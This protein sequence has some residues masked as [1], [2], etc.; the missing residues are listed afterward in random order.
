[1]NLPVETAWAQQRRVQNI[2][3]VRRSDQD[4]TFAVAEAVHLYQQLVEGLL[5]LIVSTTGSGS[6]LATNRVDLVDEDDT[7]PIF[8]SLLNQVTHARC[9]NTDEHFYEVRAGDG[10]ERNA[11]LARNRASQQ[12]L[13]CTRRAI[14]QHAAW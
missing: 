7:R 5:A 14:E 8:L 11:C 13:T 10:V 9:T 1:R 6:T 12:S 3:A 4:N 2:R